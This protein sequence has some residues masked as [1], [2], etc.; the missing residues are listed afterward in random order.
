LV[1][2]ETGYGR[3]VHGPSWPAVSSTQAS[4][5]AQDWLIFT[6]AAL[7]LAALVWALIIVA[8]IRFRRTD[9]NPEPRSQRANNTTLEIVWTV[10]PL[11]IV[12]ALFAYTYHIEAGVEALAADA[13]VAVTV[14]GFRWGWTFAYAG[15]PTITGTSLHPPQLVLPAGETAAISVTSSDVIHSFWIPDMLFKRDAIP[16]RVTTFDLTPTTPGTYLGRCGEFCGL[17]H[18]LMTFTVRVVAPA[19]YQRWRTGVV[20]Q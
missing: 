5:L 3:Q 7:G 12:T 6:C 8:A 13:P 17:N 14:N 4:A 1:E 2:R 18:A 16:G 10:V 15:G 11:L 20:T 9:R 19:E